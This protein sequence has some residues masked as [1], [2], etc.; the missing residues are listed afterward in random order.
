MKESKDQKKIQQERSQKIT[1]QIVPSFDLRERRTPK[2]PKKIKLARVWNKQN[3][4]AKI[5]KKAVEM[6]KSP[7]IV[8]LSDE[9][10]ELKNNPR[11]KKMP[12]IN[13]IFNVKEF[14]FV[15]FGTIHYYGIIKSIVDNSYEIILLDKELKIMPFKEL[16]K[17]IEMKDK[18]RCWVPKKEKDTCQKNIDF[19]VFRSSFDNYRSVLTA[20]LSENE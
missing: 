2:P 15:K 14:I 3:N 8:K 13:H 1:K 7:P 19:S 17:E 12:K 5:I 6:S 20:L 16:K 10:H 18:D 9:N 4:K 11:Q